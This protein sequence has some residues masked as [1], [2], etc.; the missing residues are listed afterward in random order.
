MSKDPKEKADKRKEEKEPRPPRPPM[1]FDTRHEGVKLRIC[2]VETVARPPLIEDPYE[3]IMIVVEGLSPIVGPCAPNLNVYMALLEARLKKGLLDQEAYDRI[4]EEVRGKQ[5]ERMTSD[6]KG[7]SAGQIATE[8]VKATVNLFA[9]DAEGC[10]GLQSYS[11]RAALREC[12]SR[13]G[14]FVENRGTREDFKHGTGVWPLFIRLERGDKPIEAADDIHVKPDVVHSKPITQADDIH[15]AFRN[16]EGKIVSQPVHVFAGGK[17]QHS[18]SQFEVIDPPW[19][20]RMMVEARRDAPIKLDDVVRVLG[21]LP[22][23]AWGAKRSMGYGR[24]SLVLASRVERVDPAAPY[25]F[26]WKDVRVA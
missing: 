12:F 23:I 6:E 26:T 3:R 14:F 5:V 2:G 25:P 17:P 11:F 21:L 16:D 4:T 10:L 24:C 1:K 13:S 19:R 7:D 15:V 20:A 18:I 8:V 9:R 22:T